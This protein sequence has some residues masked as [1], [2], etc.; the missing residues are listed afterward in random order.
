M[1]RALRFIIFS[2][3]LLFLAGSALSQEREIRIGIIASLT[4]PAGEQGKNWSN[5]SL[6]AAEELRQNGLHLQTYLEDDGSS[7]INVAKAFNRLAN[8]QKVDAIIGGTWDFLA[9]VAYPIALRSKIP[10]FT[11]TNSPEFLE[12]SATGN[13]FV[14]TNAPRISSYTIPIQNLFR[15]FEV[16]SIALL[17]PDLPFGIVQASLM[18]SIAKDLAVEVVYEEKFPME[19]ALQDPLRVAALKIAEKKPDLV[20]ALCDY[21]LLDLFLGELQ[22]RAPSTKVLTAQHLDQAFLFSK[23]NRT[24]YANAF[25][26]YPVVKDSDF[27]KRYFE[28]FQESPKVYA[29]FGYDALMFLAKAIESKISLGDPGAPFQY[30]GLTGLHSLPATPDRA[31]SNASAEMFSTISGEFRRFG[32][33]E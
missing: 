4:G 30:E 2:L 26:I 31:V 29:E 16:R 9:E 3:L 6:L 18:K 8:N 1:I 5:G 15:K 20:Y 22:R 10:F 11:P 24:R 33:S 13:L 32:E 7:P 25:G 28:R 14:F 27:S 17:Y 21:A 19:T 23:R 12:K